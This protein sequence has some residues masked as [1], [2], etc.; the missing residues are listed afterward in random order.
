MA[1]LLASLVVPSSPRSSQESFR[2]I[3]S[4]SRKES[5]PPSSSK[6]SS[7]APS[8]TADTTSALQAAGIPVYDIDSYLA[9][10]AGLRSTSSA[11]NVNASKKHTTTTLSS[12]EPVSLGTRTGFHV[13]ALNTQ[14]QGKGI[15]PVFEIEGTTD[16]GGVLKLGGAVVTTD[17]RW[18][19][20]KE[21]K[22]GLAEKG[23]EVVKKIGARQ[24]SPGEPKEQGKNWVGLLHGAYASRPFL[25]FQRVFNKTN[26][27]RRVP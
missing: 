17:Q 4:Q 27:W 7:P 12:P 11:N 2:S 5:P 3:A 1:D 15:L 18:R 16:F 24:K 19:S 22:E 25:G 21:A 8:S 26:L 6:L 14:C 23:L 9:Q 20:K 10:N 13:S